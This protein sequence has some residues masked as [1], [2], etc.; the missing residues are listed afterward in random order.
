MATSDGT[1]V[2]LVRHAETRSYAADTGLTERGVA[3]ARAT[4][5][6]LAAAVA[7]EPVVAVECAGTERARQTA[8]E[9][10]QALLAAPGA[11]P[12]A[13]TVPAVVE[14]AAF[15]NFQ[16]ATPVGCLEVTAAF[17][18]YDRERRRRDEAGTRAW[19]LVEMDRFWTL[20]QNGGD[21]ISLW[22]QVPL[23]HFE[24]PA[25]T[26]T[27]L[28]SGL[29]RLGREHR[30]GHAVVVTHSG[31]MRA[32]LLSVAGR[33]LGEPA[34]AEE[35]LVRLDVDSAAATVHFRDETCV[36]PV[37]DVDAIPDRW[38]GA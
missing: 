24:P 16:V 5:A 29:R 2:H 27:R 14:S 33:D 18:L 4:G 3:Q 37:P 1:T 35:V 38:T 22:T 9:L 8:G 12:L 31:P 11:G 34:H 7:G 6:R 23:L 36:V 10:R 26:V 19:W 28:W 32:L 17:G 21:P 30:G 25:T 13:A 20:Q 15:A